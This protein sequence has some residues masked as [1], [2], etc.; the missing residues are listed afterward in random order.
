MY[1]IVQV[2]KRKK[3]NPYGEYRE[4]EV[5]SMTIQFQ[6]GTSKTK[7]SY[8]PKYE[9]GRFERP[10]RES[11]KISIHESRRD[12]GKVVKK[13][14]AIGTV[15]YYD[16]LQWCLYDYIDKGVGRAVE[17]FG[18]DYETLYKLVEDKMQP[19][20]EKI[21]KEFHRSEEYK[22]ERQRKKLEKAY[23]RAKKQFGAQ[24]DVDPDEYDY[25][26]NIFGELMEKAYLDKI[27]QQYEQKQK[28]QSSYRKSWGSTYGQY[29]S[30]SYSIPPVST[31]SEDETAIL[32]Q[33]Y[34]AL[35]KQ[36][37]P[38]VNH[39]RDTTRE[40]QLLNRLKEQWGV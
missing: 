27:I 21:T 10:H 32:K 7:Y 13:Q 23:Q 6:D 31:Y 17:M 9:S 25:C 18:V 16:L 4:Y 5:G 1:C 22:A 8:Y 15:G 26:Y 19:I 3:P 36:F 30:S 39:D 33:F 20:I 28:A 12:G 14:C 34:R 38:D 40:L 2:L 24:Y 37:H 11:Y 29:S 35:A